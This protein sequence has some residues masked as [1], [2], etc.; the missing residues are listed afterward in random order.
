M[1]DMKIP[2][3]AI[4][5]V[6][7]ILIKVENPGEPSV[8]AIYEILSCGFYVQPNV[9]EERRSRAL[10]HKRKIREKFSTKKLRVF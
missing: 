5:A 2:D 1:A 4:T 7:I 9:P 10:F 6:I 3:V 8:F